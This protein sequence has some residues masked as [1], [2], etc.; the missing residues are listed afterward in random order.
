MWY[1]QTEVATKTE[2]EKVKGMIDVSARLVKTIQLDGSATQLVECDYAI[3]CHSY[4]VQNSNNE[5]NAIHTERVYITPG[6]SATMMSNNG[7]TLLYVVLTLS[8][9]Y[10]LSADTS[11]TRY[12]LTN[13]TALCYK[14]Q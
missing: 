8:T 14:Y 13:T 1:N 4:G 10:R 2:L 3:I 6:G 7:K 11:I 5:V 12:P 9:S